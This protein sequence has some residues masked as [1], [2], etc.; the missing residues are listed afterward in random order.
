[1]FETGLVKSCQFDAADG[2]DS[3][4]GDGAGLDNR[5]GVT[6]LVCFTDIVDVNGG[7]RCTGLCDDERNRDTL[8]EADCYGDCTR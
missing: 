1:M 3:A 7:C 8:R 2:D 5:V 4:L 6:G